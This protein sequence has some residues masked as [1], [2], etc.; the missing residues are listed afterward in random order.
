MTEQLLQFAGRL[1]PIVVHFPIAMVL[2]AAMIEV[3]RAALR[4]PGPARTSINMLAIGVAASG[5]AIGS[6]WL[7]ADF[8]HG[9]GNTTLELHRWVAIGGGGGALLALLIGIAARGNR[10]GVAAFRASLVIASGAIGFAGHLGG[11]LVYGEGYLF[12]PFASRGS[13]DGNAAPAAEPSEEPSEALTAGTVSFEHDV[14]PVLESRCVECHGPTRA[15]GGL[16]L[17]SLEHALGV[18]EWVIAPGDPDASDMIVRITAAEDEDGAMPP[19]G[20]RL[21]SAQIHAVRVWIESLASEGQRTERQAVDVPASGEDEYE[22]GAPKD[23]TDRQEHPEEAAA[24]DALR[25]IGA[26]VLPVAAG[27]ELLDVN[28]SLAGPGCDDEALQMLR[29]IAHRV[30]WLRA[31]GPLVT[32]AAM[33]VV[34]ECKALERL[35]LSA[36][37]LTDE[38]FSKVVGLPAL[39]VLT[40]TGTRV[41]DA[42]LTGGAWSPSL[43]RVY[44]WGTSVTSEGA[45]RLASERPGVVLVLDGAEGGAWPAADEHQREPGREP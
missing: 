2:A 11:T 45:A 41:T 29:P 30:R 16:R 24:I 6:G 36:S 39:R 35:D 44:A 8:E 37:G 14:L 25:A 5:A 43:A 10:G 34:A 42:A 20:E 13:P 4:R 7:N 27:S 31:T 15:K 3:T 33:D 22:G 26:H 28:L 17:D 19:K 32:D 23:G 40:M 1:H 18:D 12:A 9:S 38:G 21:S